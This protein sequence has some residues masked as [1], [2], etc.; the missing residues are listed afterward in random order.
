MRVNNIEW[1]NIDL[2]CTHTL[3]SSAN[4]RTEKGIRRYVHVRLTN[5]F[6]SS[7]INL[8]LFPFNKIDNKQYTL[9]DKMIASL[10]IV[11]TL[12]ADK[13]VKQKYLNMRETS[14]LSSMAYDEC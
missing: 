11:M 7:K 1:K 13:V 6:S 4:K 14:P 2:K 9:R 8:R 3:T 12:L 10:S 5:I